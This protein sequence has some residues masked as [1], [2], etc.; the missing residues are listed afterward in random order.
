MKL[1]LT[2]NGSTQSKRWVWGDRE[3]GGGERG[4]EGDGLTEEEGNT[5]QE[6][7][8]KLRESGVIVREKPERNNESPLPPTK[9]AMSGP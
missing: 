7:Q 5:K 9:P 2:T 1:E 3:R 6:E 8:R 4:R